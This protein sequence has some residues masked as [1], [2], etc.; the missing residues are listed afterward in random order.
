MF[1]EF[2]STATWLQF[3]FL[4][5][6]AK[7][8]VYESTAK[9]A[10]HGKIHAQTC[11]HTYV[12][13]IHYSYAFVLIVHCT[14]AYNVNMNACLAPVLTVFMFMWPRFGGSSSHFSALDLSDA[15]SA[16]HALCL[17]QPLLQSPEEHQA[18]CQHDSEKH[19]YQ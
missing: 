5:G 3:P 6:A 10:R 18:L 9:S 11:N 4:C 15:G 14:F 1:K 13:M 16:V 19:V 12:D 17:P 8:S 7:D 2:K